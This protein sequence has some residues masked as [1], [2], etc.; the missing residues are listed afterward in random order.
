VRLAAVAAIVVFAC[1]VGGN[2]SG[3][4]IRFRSGV[5]VVR[6]DA[7]VTE[8]RRIVTGLLATDF[9]LRDNGVL[10]T[11]DALALESMPLT[12]TFVLDTSGSVDSG[13]M[14]DLTSAV[15]I[16]LRGLRA[17]DRVALVTFSHRLWQRLPLTSD[18]ELVRNLLA[19]ARGAGGTSL[20]DAVYAGL[21]LSEAQ[22]A[23]S[24][25][26]VFSD[27]LDNSSWLPR[28]TVERAAR[29]A[30]AVVYGV[31]VAG[32]A[33][34]VID[35]G[36]GRS[37]RFRPEYL[38]G[39][40]DFLDAVTSATGGRVVKADDTVKLPKAFDEI[41]QEFRTRYVITY[42]PASNAPGWHAIDLKVKGRRAE[43][44]ARRGYERT[45]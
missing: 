5:D 18:V 16:L 38:P 43:V 11:I 33:Q 30:D 3:Q 39:Q 17:Q 20:N 8:D 29:R 7:L 35:V 23:R 1:I 41:L 36:Q 10:Q 27:G 42:S 22:E 13:K 32:G 26:L 14:A 44:K 24:L 19:G 28:G 40:T 25:V 6:V 45:R 9:E 12:L 21:A 4:D 2:V 34:A 37:V 15:D 31:V